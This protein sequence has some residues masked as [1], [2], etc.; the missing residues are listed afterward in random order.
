MGQRTMA[1]ADK[2]AAVDREGVADG[3]RRVV[4]AQPQRR[5]GD[6]GRL[7]EATEQAEPIGD[8]LRLAA[9]RSIAARSIGV[10]MAPGQ[11]ALMR[12]PS[13]A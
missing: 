12:M 7:A 2:V 3:E 5:L 6:L 4:R 11:M 1:S 9:P 8:L 13:A 10:S